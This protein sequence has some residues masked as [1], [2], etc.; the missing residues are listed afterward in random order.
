MTVI[1]WVEEG[2]LRAFKTVGGHRRILREDLESFC[3]QRRIPFGDGG[4]V[5]ARPMRIL[6]AMSSREADELEVSVRAAAPE[7]VVAVAATAFEAGLEIG[8]QPPDVVIVGAMP[9][10]EATEVRSLVG[11][12]SGGQRAIRVLAV[13]GETARNSALAEAGATVLDPRPSLALLQSVLGGGLGAVVP[14]D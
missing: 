5:E 6:L 9:S 3:R 7:A 14:K 2:R 13:G 12:G 10:V 8:R 4:E 11:R 1:R